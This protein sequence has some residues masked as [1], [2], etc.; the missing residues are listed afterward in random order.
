VG[1]LL[2]DLKLITKV[3]S[4]DYVTTWDQTWEDH[5]GLTGHIN[6][7]SF[8]HMSLVGVVQ[9]TCPSKTC[10]LLSSPHDMEV[11]WH[12]G[13]PNDPILIGF[14]TIN[15]P[16]IGVPPFVETQKM[17]TQ[18][19]HSALQLL[20]NCRY[21]WMSWSQRVIHRFKHQDI[22]ITTP[23]RI[24]QYFFKIPTKIVLQFFSIFLLEV[25]IDDKML[26]YRPWGLMIPLSYLS[27]LESQISF[28]S[29]PR[30]DLGN[31]S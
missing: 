21:V 15:H 17:E 30:I 19:N 26:C 18:L 20:A 29:C 7:S 22:N 1:P 10:L 24:E 27:G 16:A 8:T 9:T 11:S 13:T 31:V 3:P 23:Q 28:L 4:F 5:A 12:G 6:Q 14:F 25:T 2:D